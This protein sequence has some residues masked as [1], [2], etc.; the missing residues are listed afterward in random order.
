[1]KGFTLVELM[2][3]MLIFS[4]ILGA[5]FAVMNIGKTSWHLGDAQVEM[6]Q[7]ARK[8]M[9]W[10]TKELRQSG[11]SAIIGVPAD[12]NFYSTI[13]FR[14]PDEDGIDAN[15][16]IDWGNQISY[17]LGGLNGQ[18]L[19]RTVGGESTVLANRVVNLQFGRQVAT[20][21]IVE[22]TLQSQKTAIP[23]HLMSA[24]LNS[25]IRFRN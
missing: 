24:T 22:I 13:T 16:N 4:I 20:P 6:Q 18:Q 2:I 11:S 8:G 17:S 25:Q 3:V 15:G 1:M 7:E 5:V 9:D 12:G 14:V 19:L 23:G 21:N 10:M